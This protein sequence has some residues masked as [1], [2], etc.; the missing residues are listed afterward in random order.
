MTAALLLAA[1]ATWFS[2]RPVRAIRRRRRSRAPGRRRAVTSASTPPSG[3]LPIA[4]GAAIAMACLAVGGWPGG[5]VPAAI[6]SPV[7]FGLVRW[8]R[9]RARATLAAADRAWIPLTLDLAAASLLAGQPLPAALASAAP[10]ARP[11]LAALFEQVAGMLRMGA[12]PADAW[13]AFAAEPQLRPV[14]VTAIRGAT[15]GIKLAAGFT[16]LATELRADARSAAQARAQRAGVW[17]IAPLGLCFLPAF[18]CV[19]IVPVVI[20]VANGLLH[21]TFR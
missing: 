12:Q 2:I 21:S 9:D 6:L 7:A 15:S 19:G 4:A 11:D 13:Q 18:V 16:E 20:G 17:A 5:A 8:L 1:L 3:R 10:R 14:A